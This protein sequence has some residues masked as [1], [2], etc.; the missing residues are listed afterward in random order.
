MV[1]C[2]FC[3]KEYD[4]K[5]QLG[6]HIVYCIENPNKR[7]T[8]KDTYYNS[9][10]K[11]KQCDS[12]I[13]FDK[14][15]N[16]FCNSS[17]S[18]TFNN[19]IRDWRPDNHFK[20]TLSNK[21]TLIAKEN[22]KLNPKKCKQCDSNLSYENRKEK[23]CSKE[24]YDKKIVSN[25]S[26]CGSYIPYD[27][28][29]RKT[30]SDECLN[31]K[32]KEGGKIGGRKSAQ[33]QAESRRSK[34]ETLFADKCIDYFDKVLTN[35]SMFNGWDADVIIEDIKV[36]VLWN[37]KW[38]YEKITEKHSVKQVQNRDKI[39]LDEIKKCGY[40]P[41]VIKD[42]GKFNEEKVQKEFDKF[43]KYTAGWTSG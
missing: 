13:Q 32:L 28:R 1:K 2:K 11:C 8:L 34:N 25:C 29:K 27:K 16:D 12:I 40:I 19:N 7:K 37:G 5:S 43:I 22:Y 18:A 30:C 21:F 33:V 24:C 41:Y 9:P 20:E 31:L 6:G 17:C 35:E 38:H 39:K 42:M 14:R 23:F 4:N 26:V 10:K 36:A 15:E 3:D